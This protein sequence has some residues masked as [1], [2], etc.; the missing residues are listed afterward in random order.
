MLRAYGSIA[1]A[2]VT[3]AP[4]ATA[5]IDTGRWSEA[6]EHLEEVATL[7]VVYNMQALEADAAALRE[8]LRALRGQPADGP[9]SIDPYWT[10]I[11][12]AENRAAHVWLLRAAAAVATAA[13][14]FDGAY[15]HLRQLF[16]DNGVPLHYFLAHRV[17]ADLA[18][19]AQRTGRQEDVVPI[20]AAV[21]EAVGPEPTTRMTLL[22]HHAEAL[23]GDP[24]QAEQNFRLAVVNPAAEQWPLARAQ[25]RL[26]YAQWLRRRRR[27][28]EARALLTAALE[29]FTRLGASI[30]AEETRSELRASGVTMTSATPDPLVALTAQEL[31]IARM[32]ARGLSNREIAEQLILSPR[33]IGAHLYR[34]YPKLGVTSRHQ[35]RDFLDDE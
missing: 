2:A 30:L 16:D 4:M 19:A 24:K 22:L 8:T 5:L 7:A 20:V 15:R 21:R 18:A 33:T 34:V 14:D 13:G 17:I 31:Q 25:A 23:V 32:A 1:L 35:L 6:D 26:H 29:S 3:L 10:R 12:L 27:P 28:L 9:V 11:D